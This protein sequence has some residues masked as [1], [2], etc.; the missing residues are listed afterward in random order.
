MASQFNEVPEP[1]ICDAYAEP[2]GHWVIRRGEPAEKA[3]GREPS[4]RFLQSGLFRLS[5]HPNFF[6]EQAQWWVVF[7]FGCVAAGSLLQW[8]VIG[9]L[10]LTGLFGI[11][12]FGILLMQKPAMA[13][14][15]GGH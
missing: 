4:P 8:T 12:A 9:P 7:L 5:R 2:T 6:F 13:T 14:A 10:L 1:I 11:L 15:G 3:A